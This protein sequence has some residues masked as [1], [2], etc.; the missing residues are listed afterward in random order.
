MY[1]YMFMYIYIYIQRHD[2]NLFIWLTLAIHEV[3]F[4]QI[5]Y[6]FTLILLMQIVL[7]GEFP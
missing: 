7:C 2:E 1:I 6:T 4:N 5:Y 3:G